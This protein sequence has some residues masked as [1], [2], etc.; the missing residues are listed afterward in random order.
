[1]KAYVP[2]DLQDRLENVQVGSHGGLTFD[3][4]RAHE[5]GSPGRGVSIGNA[6][7]RATF[8]ADAALSDPAAVARS[9]YQGHPKS[10]FHAVAAKAGLLARKGIDWGTA[11][12]PRTLSTAALL[13][14]LAGAGAGALR[15]KTTGAPVSDGALRWGMGAGALGLGAVG[16]LMLANDRAMQGDAQM[17]KTSSL[18]KSAADIFQALASDNTLSFFEKA[19]LSG[20]IQRLSWQ[21]QQQLSSLVRATAGAGVGA[22]IARFLANRGFLGTIAGALLGGLLAR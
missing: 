10:L 4:S 17:R 5:F 21:D 2:Y 16:A 13:S 14:A 8:D 7:T 12:R 3:D 11:T 20:A 22:I 19:E 6:Q 1:M 15:A 9:R 18:R